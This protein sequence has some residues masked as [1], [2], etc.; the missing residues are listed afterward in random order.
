L[1][2]LIYYIQDIENLLE[3]NKS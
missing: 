1:K 3:N 2:G